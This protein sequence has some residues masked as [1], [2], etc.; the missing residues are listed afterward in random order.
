LFF[1]S[2]FDFERIRLRYTVTKKIFDEQMLNYSKYELKGS[3]KLAQCLEIPH[4]C[5]W[6]GYNLSILR[7]E[8]PGPEPWII[9]LKEKLSQPVH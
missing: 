8:D 9:E 3:T 2:S 7:N 5:A 4:Y 1:E 6:L